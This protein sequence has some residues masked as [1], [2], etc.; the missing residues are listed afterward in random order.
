MP[1]SGPL[2]TYRLSERFALGSR[3]AINDLFSDLPD[4]DA[5]VY[6]QGLLTIVADTFDSEECLASWPGH[7]FQDRS[8]IAVTAFGDLF[9]ASLGLGRAHAR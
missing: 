3:S 8:V 2:S 7:M 4:V 9:L 5:G 6:N 1:P